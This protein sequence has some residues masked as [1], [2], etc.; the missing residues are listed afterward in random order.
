MRLE[1]SVYCVSVVWQLRVEIVPVVHGQPISHRFFSITLSDRCRYEE[2]RSQA[3]DSCCLDRKR[4][5]LLVMLRVQSWSGRSVVF[6]VN[7]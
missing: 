2:E 4:R 5:A 7:M 6:R 3:G 1:S